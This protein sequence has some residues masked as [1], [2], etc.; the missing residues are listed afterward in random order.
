M[1]TVLHTAGSRGDD[2]LNLVLRLFNIV[3]QKDI[4]L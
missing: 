4:I 3:M 2:N 1:Q